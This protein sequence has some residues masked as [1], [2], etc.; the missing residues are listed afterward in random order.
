M[1]V[2]LVKET[3]IP[4]RNILIRLNH[5]NPPT[6]NSLPLTIP[7]AI[8]PIEAQLHDNLIAGKLTTLIP[9]LTLSYYC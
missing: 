6:G 5:D 9:H 8:S 7:L 1:Q 2:P 4:P 3:T